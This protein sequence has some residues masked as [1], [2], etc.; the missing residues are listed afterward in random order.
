[1]YK[2]SK[3]KNSIRFANFLFVYE[4]LNA[5]N[6]YNIVMIRLQVCEKF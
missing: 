6:A 5:Q 4:K 2:I 1:M 3:A